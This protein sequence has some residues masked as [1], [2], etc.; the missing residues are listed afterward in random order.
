MLKTLYTICKLTNFIFWTGIYKLCYSR[1]DFFENLFFRLYK[2]N[3]IMVKILQCSANNNDLWAPENKELIKKYTDNVPFCK[4]DIDYGTLNELMM[5]KQIIFEKL[6]EPLHSGTISLVYKATYLDN[7]VIVKV[8]RKNIED[9]LKKDSEEIQ[10]IIFLCNCVP[11]LNKLQIEDNYNIYKPLLETQCDFKQEIINQNLN[12]LNFKNYE[13]MKVPMI[14]EDRCTK[15]SIVMEYV[16]GMNISEIKEHDKNIYMDIIGHIMVYSLIVYGFFTCDAHSGN[17]IFMKND[18]K[19]KVCVI[20]FGICGRN[21][22]AEINSFYEL[23]TYIAESDYDNSTKI[24]L[25]NFTNCL[26]ENNKSYDDIFTDVKT[27]F[28]DSFEVNKEFSFNEIYKLYK[29][30]KKYDIYT[31]ESWIKTELGIASIDGCMKEL[32]YNNIGLTDII[33]QKVN[34]LN[35]FDENFLS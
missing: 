29:I 13:H 18:N 12:K 20:D 28:Y 25:E 1:K 33:K 5:D 31:N 35:E 17:L 16:K 32:K 22:I 23:F 15:N 2:Y 8:K 7:D 19:Y 21:S 9:R 27:I 26:K 10:S 11:Y 24:F 3:L 14:Y 6:N 34:S 4:D 30:L